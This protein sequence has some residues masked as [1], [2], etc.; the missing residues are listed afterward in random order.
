M[1]NCLRFITS[2]K[3]SLNPLTHGSDLADRIEKRWPTWITLKSLTGHAKG[4]QDAEVL[5]AQV[6]NI[7]KQRQLLEE[8]DLI[9]PLVTNLTQL[10]TRKIES[11]E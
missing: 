7:E 4:I 1:N 8:P 2:V 6:A 10:L 11:S 9:S 5:L 3:N